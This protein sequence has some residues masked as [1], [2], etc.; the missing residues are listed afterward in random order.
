MTIPPRLMKAVAGTGGSAQ[1]PR[2][3]YREVKVSLAE[4]IAALDRETGKPVDVSHVEFRSIEGLLYYR[5]ATREGVYLV[6][7][8][9]A[10]LLTVTEDVAR[11]IAAS[12]GASPKDIERTTLVRAH[13]QDYLWGPLPAWRIEVADDRR[14][15]YYVEVP[16]GEVRTTHRWGRVL[17]FLTGMHT[18]DFLSP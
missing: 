3:D 9:D 12:K 16:G 5:V 11:R 4:A 8:R 10:A 6:S 7:G 18:L 1:E 2:N 14:T 17:G 15:A 13:D